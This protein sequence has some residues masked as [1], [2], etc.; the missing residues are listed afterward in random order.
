MSFLKPDSAI[1]YLKGVGPQRGALLRKQL[2]IHDVQS[3]LFYFPFRYIDKTQIHQIKDIE[4]DGQWVQLR[5]QALRMGDRGQGR[6]KPLVAVVKDSTGSL[7]L[8]W[9]RSQKWVEDHFLAGRTYQIYGK[10]QKS[11]YGF[12]ISHPRLKE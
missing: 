12:S 11:A 3:L 5:V 1:E 6:G 7:E 8:V 10:V 4:F 9:F 2:N